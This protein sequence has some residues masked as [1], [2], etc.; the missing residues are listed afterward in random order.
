MRAVESARSEQIDQFTLIN[1]IDSA[2]GEMACACEAFEDLA[3]LLEAI[4]NAANEESLAYRLAKAGLR[5]A[6][7]KATAFQ[8]ERDK[9]NEHSR[10]YSGIVSAGLLRSVGNGN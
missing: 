3:A 1:H 7:D 4:S 2:A 5:I 6:D 10:R 9:Y 8:I